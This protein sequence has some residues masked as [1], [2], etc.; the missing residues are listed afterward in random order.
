MFRYEASSGRVI[1]EKGK[2]LQP[3]GP[4]KDSDQQSR[5]IYA[6]T[7]VEDDRDKWDVTYVKEYE[8]EQLS[9]GDYNPDWGFKI[10]TD[11]HIVSRMGSR[12]YVDLISNNVV[13]KRPNGF[14]SQVW[15][16]DNTTKTIRSR[17]TTSY[18]LQ[19]K[20]SGATSGKGMMVIT[21]TASRWW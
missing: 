18:S 1:N 16:F 7:P 20:S 3:Q 11:F 12:K 13:L 21:S 2:V 15:Y 17:R 14:N 19:I 9:K 4:Y 8:A 5:Y 10:E 6:A